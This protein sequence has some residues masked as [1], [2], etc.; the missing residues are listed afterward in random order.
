MASGG[1]TSFGQNTQSELTRAK[2]T[3]CGRSRYMTGYIY[4]GSCTPQ[5]PI[6]S[7][8]ANT[9]WTVPSF[10]SDDMF[11][12]FF[13]DRL[14]WTFDYLFKPR[15][16]FS[17]YRNANWISLCTHA[18]PSLIYFELRR[19]FGTWR[20]GI[21]APKNAFLQFVGKNSLRAKFPI[22]AKLL[23]DRKIEQHFASFCIF[24]FKKKIRRNLM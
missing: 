5:T 8:T 19:T 20:R 17:A 3:A 11:T 12:N 6:G 4:L 24:P 9:F 7:L 21:R 10:G 1:I 16:N 15:N 22:R 13:S 23:D 2:I 14:I 18:S